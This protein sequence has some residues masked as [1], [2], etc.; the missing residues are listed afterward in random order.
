MAELALMD[1]GRVA[2]F[3]G[4][5]R[6]LTSFQRAN[7]MSLLVELAPRAAHHGDCAGA[8][9]EM[10]LLCVGLQIPVFIH[11][12]DDPRFR[13]HCHFL[14]DGRMVE[15]V[16]EEKPYLVRDRDIVVASDYLVACVKGPWERRSGTWT[17]VGYAEA[18]GIPVFLLHPDGRVDRAGGSR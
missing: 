15:K 1:R 11:P 9:V 18:A 6:G 7:L 17:T 3:T 13:G 2:G 5:R 16:F 8:D 14:G 12:P 10:H 4:T